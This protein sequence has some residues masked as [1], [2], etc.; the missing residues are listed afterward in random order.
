[1]TTFSLPTVLGFKPGSKVSVINPPAGFV[2]KRSK[3]KQQM[4]R[5]A[6]RRPMM[7]KISESR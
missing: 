2:Q 4:A 3:T 7:R 1:M 6:V 5:A